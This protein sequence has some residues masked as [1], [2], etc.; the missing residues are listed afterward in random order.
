MKVFKKLITGALFLTLLMTGCETKTDSKSAVDLGSAVGFTILSKS[1]IDSTGE[2]VVTG[3]IGVS[4]VAASYIT[5]FILS[6]DGSNLYST[7]GLVSDKVYAANYSEPTP[8]NMTKAIGDMEKAYTDAAGRID[9]RST[10]LGAGDISGLT[11]VPGIYKWGTG[12]LIASDVTLKGGPNDIWIFQIAGGLTVSSGAKV[13]L[14]GGGMPKNIFW[15]SF[16]PVV[17]DTTAHIEGVV[18]CKTEI[19]LATG[20]TVNGRL[21]SQ[22]AVTIDASTVTGPS[23]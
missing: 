17:M 23:L 7:S 8:T 22:T 16:G 21:L 13:L 3:S 4:P 14:S 10:E 11:I 19:S 1:G 2:S 18:L 9:P 5:G 6:M 12:V 20:A 15:Q